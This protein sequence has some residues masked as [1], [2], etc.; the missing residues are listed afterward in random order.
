MVD[1]VPFLILENGL[2]AKMG[3]EDLFKKR[4]G[5]KTSKDLARKEATKAPLMKILIACEG[6]KTEPT[7]FEDLIS[8]FGLLT[9]SVIDVTGESGSSPMCVVKHAK[10]KQEDMAAQGAPYDKIYIVIDKDAHVDYLRALD[11]IKRAKPNKVWFTVNSVPCFEFWLLLHYTYSTKEYRG[12]P[13]KSAGDQVVSEL[14]KYIK[15]Y[16]K[17]AKGIFYKTFN[18]LKTKDLNEVITK[19]KQS[20]RAAESSGTDNP[21]TKVHELIETL[22]ELKEQININKGKKR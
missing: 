12:L 16:D 4:R 5:P 18:S 21:S 14:K 10:K 22:M 15:G 13:G 20:L 17:A 6:E 19:A 8:H 7:Y 9:A 2:G 3:S 1:T 11:A